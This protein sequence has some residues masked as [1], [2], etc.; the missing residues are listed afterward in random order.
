MANIFSRIQPSVTL[1][2]V[3]IPHTQDVDF[4]KYVGAKT[5]LGDVAAQ[6]LYITTINNVNSETSV[7][8]QWGQDKTRQGYTMGQISAPYYI[9]R[10]YIEYARDERAIFESVSNGMSLPTFLENVAK[11]GINQRRG[12]G[13]LFG[14]DSTLNQGILA[15]ATEVTMPADSNGNASVSTY[16]ITELQVF[17]SKLVADMQSNTLNTAKPLV[18]TS[19]FRVINYLKSAIYGLKLDTGNVAIDSVAN[20]FDKVASQ[21]LGAKIEFVANDLL[22]GD[23]QDTIAL[24]ARGVS[25]D[26]TDPTISQNLAAQGGITYNTMYDAAL[27]LIREERPADFGLYSSELTYKMTSGVT[28]RNESVIKIKVAF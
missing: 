5:N 8:Q 6:S 21:W 12:Q 1:P 10:A 13:I 3:L 17:L 24:I 20:V 27:D 14:F 11:Q 19:S 18:F 9:I 7:G 16:N 15:N 28:L 23:T 4:H 2:S 26:E 25:P 22:K